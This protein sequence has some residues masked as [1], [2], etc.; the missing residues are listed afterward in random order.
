M[1]MKLNPLLRRD[2]FSFQITEFFQPYVLQWLLN[3]D[4]KTQQWVEAVR[5]FL[6]SPCVTPV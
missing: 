4:N 1:A 5:F 3:T 2:D 6:S